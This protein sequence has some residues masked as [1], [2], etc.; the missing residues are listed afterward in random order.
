VGTQLHRHAGVGE[1]L[2]SPPILRPPALRP[3]AT[4]G[5]VAPA[6]PVDEEAL[7]RGAAALETA[8]FRVRLADSVLA[9]HGY[10]AGSDAQ[11]LS[12]WHAMVEAADVDAIFAA[13]GGYGSGRLL[14]QLDAGLLRRHPKP[15]VGHSDLTF[16]LNDMLQRAGVVTFHGPMV[17]WFAE[18]PAS[19]AALLALLAGEGPPTLAAED[20]WV[21]GEAEGI[22]AGGCLSL[23]AAMVG[24]PY[25]VETRGRLLFLE[26]VNEKPYRVDRMLTQ[27]RQSGAFDGIA[28]LLF[29]E[30]TNCFE[31]E[32]VCL[33]DIAL[34]LCGDLGVPIVAGIPSGHGR[35][36]V[37]LPLGA[38]AHLRAGVL[39]FLEPAVDR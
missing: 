7:R 17:S 2:I 22:L 27:L 3:G 28:A 34:D 11:R 26:D 21:E 10:L 24:T 33:R 15:V 5:V 31:G 38:R 37:T 14:P 13:R 32:E 18:R 39:T 4:I 23:V 16:V 25:A 8:G 29:G 9:R 19:T 36:L 20:V 12:D 30:M 35:G 1:E 6:G